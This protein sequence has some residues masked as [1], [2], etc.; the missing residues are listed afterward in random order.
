M[1]ARLNSRQY[2]FFVDFMADVLKN[3]RRHV[4]VTRFV[5]RDAT[6]KGHAM[7]FEVRITKVGELR[8]PPIVRPITK[9]QLIDRLVR[10]NAERFTTKGKKR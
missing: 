10:L 1:S 3:A 5:H 9:Q 4:T 6:E 8:Y 7:E 2:L